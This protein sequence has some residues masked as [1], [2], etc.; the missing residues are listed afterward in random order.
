VPDAVLGRSWLPFYSSFDTTNL[1]A[2]FQSSVVAWTT[3][4]STSPGS[5]T[6]MHNEAGAALREDNVLG[7]VI[8]LIDTQDTLYHSASVSQHAR[9]ERY[10]LCALCAYVDE[11]GRECREEMRDSGRAGRQS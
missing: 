2:M 11:G 8:L 10:V 1:D 4:A 9:M 7:R 6:G 5:N 3:P